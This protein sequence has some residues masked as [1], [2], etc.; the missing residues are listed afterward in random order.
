MGFTIKLLTY[1]ETIK[2]IQNDIGFA[3]KIQA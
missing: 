3:K 2:K 1:I